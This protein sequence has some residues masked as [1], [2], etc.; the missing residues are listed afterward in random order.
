[1]SPSPRSETRSTKRET[2]LERIFFEHEIQSPE[3]LSVAPVAE[4]THAMRTVDETLPL[5]RARSTSKPKPKPR[6]SDLARQRSKRNFFEDA[7]SVHPTSPAR[8]RV[9]GDAIVTA[10]VKTNVII[11]DEFA[12]I[13]ELAYHLSSR[14]QRP[15]SSIVITLHHGACMFFAGSFEPAYTMSVAAL[16]TQLQPTTNK[17]NAA[18]I[19]RHMAE[20]LGVPPER[21]LVRFVP[22]QEVHLAC[23]GKTVAGEVEELERKGGWPGTVDEGECGNAGGSPLG[24]ECEDG[25]S[26]LM[27]LKPTRTER[28]LT[29]LRPPTGNI[30]TPELTPP[31]SGDEGVS[32]TPGSYFKGSPE[33]DRAGF[34]HVSQPQQQQ[35]KSARRKKSFVST[36]FRRSS[37]K[38]P[39]RLSLPTI[40]DE[41]LGV[42]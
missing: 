41:R 16:A 29:A 20:T 12:F 15:V 3:A 10:E 35:H 18:L 28:S 31:G 25:S 19:Q 42:V 38:S 27:G 39:D 24:A 32:G 7:F 37:T 8:E 13:T 40:V 30:P 6:T 23:G 26:P 11:R 5:G 2:R 9:H 1:M 33:L 34:H 36:I 21:G 17:R 22:V 4:E 14:Y